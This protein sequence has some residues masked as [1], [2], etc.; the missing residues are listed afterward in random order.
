MSLRPV[1]EKM[2]FCRYF[3]WTKNWT[4]SIKNLGLVPYKINWCKNQSHTII[5]CD[6]NS[7]IGRLINKTKTH[8]FHRTGGHSITFCVDTQSHWFMWINQQHWRFKKPIFNVSLL[9]YA[10]KCLKWLSK[11]GPPE[12]SLCKILVVA[13]FPN[14][15]L[16]VK[17]QG[18]IYFFH[19]IIWYVF[20]WKFKSATSVFYWKYM[21]YKRGLISWKCH[22]K[23]SILIFKAS[24]K[25]V[26][27][28]NIC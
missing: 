9:K 21:F 22:M 3:A 25:F 28:Y 17:R 2:A 7:V 10:L 4:S 23:F 19:F 1:S 8:S 15:H 26:I 24:I 16:N 18:I 12:W 13:I 14:L 6:V 11:I 20:Y 5:I 27:K